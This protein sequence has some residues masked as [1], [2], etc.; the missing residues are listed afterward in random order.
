MCVFFSIYNS[1]FAHNYLFQCKQLLKELN[2]EVIVNKIEMSF[3]K[4][5]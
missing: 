2:Q 5:K 3:E 1:I 4:Q